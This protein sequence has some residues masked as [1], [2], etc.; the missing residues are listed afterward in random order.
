[1]F[2]HYS[3]YA[4][5]MEFG[6]RNHPL[7]D[8]RGE[9]SHGQEA[10]LYFIHDLPR[11]KTLLSLC[12]LLLHPHPLSFLPPSLLPLSSFHREKRP[13]KCVCGSSVSWLP[14]RLAVFRT[15]TIRPLV[16][17][18]LPNGPQPSVV[19]YSCQYIWLDD[20]RRRNVSRHRVSHA[21][22]CLTAHPPS[23]SAASRFF[24]LVFF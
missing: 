6:F 10:A 14:R 5:T 18:H 7:A 21:S 22:C 9:N 15:P 4:T 24:S 3:H 1:M 17:I 13:K 19:L 12:G 2:S 20:V 11:L 16:L 8:T 23:T